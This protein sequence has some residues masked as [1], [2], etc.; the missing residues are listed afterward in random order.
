MKIEGEASLF[1]DEDEFEV[2]KEISADQ[3]IN[4]DGL[5]EVRKTKAAVGTTSERAQRKTEEQESK[6]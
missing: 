6:K 1:A 3:V 2:G 5:M 4:E